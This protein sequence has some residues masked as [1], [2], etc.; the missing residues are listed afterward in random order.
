MNFKEQLYINTIAEKKSIS[1]AAKELNIS[2]PALSKYLSNL[3]Q[4]LAQPLFDKENNNYVPTFFGKKYL[5]Y[6]KEMLELNDKWEQEANEILENKSCEL[7]IAIPIMR[8][9]ALMPSIIPNF[10]QKYPSAKINLLEE[11]HNLNVDLFDEIKFDFAIYNASK[12]IDKYYYESLVVEDIVLIAAEDDK[13]LNSYERGEINEINLSLF[14][15]YNFILYPEDLSTGK[16]IY[17]RF[18]ELKINPNINL[19][20]RNTE[21]AISCASRGE[22]I[23]LA[24]L[25]Y[26]LNFKEKYPVKYV[27]TGNTTELFCVYKNG[28][29]ISEYARY[30]IDSIK[31]YYN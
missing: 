7:T 14:K 29:F 27:K 18:R 13:I 31:A 9:I 25:S 8:S 23:A 6:A 12:F 21:L 10:I 19:V 15:D 5:Y 26:V 1:K 20:T 30:F 28:K 3:E 16:K 17:Q 11:T 22:G 24:P 2:Q 4:N